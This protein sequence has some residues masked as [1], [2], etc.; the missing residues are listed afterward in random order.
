MSKAFRDKA[1]ERLRKN[2]RKQLKSGTGAGFK[3][4]RGRMTVDIADWVQV[5]DTAAPKGER[6]ESN[7]YVN[8]MDGNYR[9]GMLSD[10]KKY[11][12]SKTLHPFWEATIVKSTSKEFIFDWIWTK[13][14]YKNPDLIVSNDIRNRINNYLDQALG[15][16]APDRAQEVGTVGIEYEHG[17][18]REGQAGLEVEKFRGTSAEARVREAMDVANETKGIQN[19]HVTEIMHE[20]LEDYF[21]LEMELNKNRSKKGFLDGFVIQGRM[22]FDDRKKTMNPGKLDTT[23]KE[24][25]EKMFGGK[26]PSARF[27]KILQNYIKKNKLNKSVADLFSDSDNPIEAMPKYGVDI[28]LDNFDKAK[29]FKRGTKKLTKPDRKRGIKSKT[30]DKKLIVGKNTKTKSKKAGARRETK[31]SRPS[32]E[33]AVSLIEILNAALPEEILSRMQAP[34]LVNRTGRFRNSAKV[35]NIIVGARGGTS[36]EYTY[37]KNPYQTFEPGGK[38]GSTYRDPRRIIGQSIRELAKE[39]IGKKFVKTRRV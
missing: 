18:K 19:K 34:A 21:G 28:I 33:S 16:T 30:K 23:I 6:F 17:S 10:I 5:L 35:T 8:P 25:F 7:D 36:I 32:V 37:M 3:I 24:H 39:I 26:K 12:D 2:S 29:N 4:A 38:Q 13:G 15:T 11:V 9:S 1:L 31:N 22:T 14:E 27:T 20:Y